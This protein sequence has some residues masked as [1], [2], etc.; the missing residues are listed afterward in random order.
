ML[1]TSDKAVLLEWKGFL[2]LLLLFWFG[3]V[4][5]LVW[6]GFGGDG[7]GVVFC[8]TWQRQRDSGPHQEGTQFLS[9]GVLTLVKATDQYGIDRNS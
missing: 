3:L 7:D 9:Q 1:E 8:A 5:F 2:L 6:F 4:W